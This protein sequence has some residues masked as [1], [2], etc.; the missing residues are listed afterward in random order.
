M[1]DEFD[2]PPLPV[3]EYGDDEFCAEE[4]EPKSVKWEPDVVVAVGE[5]RSL[6]SRVRES[7]L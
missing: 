4:T 7:L 6:M 3:D 1:L 5:R 2:V